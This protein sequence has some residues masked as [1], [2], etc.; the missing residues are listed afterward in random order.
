MGLHDGSIIPYNTH[1]E[2][3]LIDLISI[4]PNN[5][6]F[7]QKPIDHIGKSQV[8]SEKYGS[9]CFQQLTTDDLCK[10][11]TIPPQ[12]SKIFS[13][14]SLKKPYKFTENKTFCSPKMPAPAKK[15]SRPSARPFHVFFASRKKTEENQQEF[16]NT[17]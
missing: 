2:Q 17:W 13:M 4:K 8:M 16:G 1:E 6:I 7:A 12:R 11:N 15:K 9:L 3:T 10:Q 5:M 14:N